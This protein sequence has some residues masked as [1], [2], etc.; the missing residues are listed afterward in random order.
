MLK[1]CAT[2]AYT[3]ILSF[4]IGGL[5]MAYVISPPTSES[6]ALHLP[7]KFATIDDRGS[8]D[9]YI[10]FFVGAEDRVWGEVA[11]PRDG[12]LKNGTFNQIWYTAN[13]G[14]RLIYAKL[15]AA[16]GWHHFQVV[17]WDNK[18]VAYIHSEDAGAQ[19]I[20]ITD[21]AATIMAQGNR[22]SATGAF[23][24]RSPQGELLATVSAADGGKWTVT[25]EHCSKIMKAT[26]ALFA[27]YHTIVSTGRAASI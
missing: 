4:L 3:A 23:N 11:I 25:V 14:S 18:V 15:S 27:G 5:A 26:Y 9:D 24:L 7:D 6:P 1:K 20:R 2:Y 17:D 8:N 10:A 12:R 13:N 22:D 16:D 21:A 19:S